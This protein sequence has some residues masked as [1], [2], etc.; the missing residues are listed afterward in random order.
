MKNNVQ[1]EAVRVGPN[2]IWWPHQK[3]PL[4]HTEAGQMCATEERSCEDR[5][6]VAIYKLRR[7]ASREIKTADTLI[8]NI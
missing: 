4:G 8:L 6:K 2:P 5:E 7:E 3:K 1:N